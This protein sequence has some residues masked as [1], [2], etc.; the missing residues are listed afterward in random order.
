MNDSHLSS[1]QK[2][3]RVRQ[4]KKE[5]TKLTEKLTLQEVLVPVLISSYNFKFTF[6]IFQFTKFTKSSCKDSFPNRLFVT[7]KRA[8]YLPMGRQGIRK[9]CGFL[10][11][12]CKIL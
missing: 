1:K 6:P 10:A 3:L 8:L 9:K 5:E 7:F 12:N 4:N 2:E 11:V